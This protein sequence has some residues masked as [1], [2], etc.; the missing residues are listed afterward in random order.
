[1]QEFRAANP[2]LDLN[3][4]RMVIYAATLIAVM[5]LRPEGV[6]G[7]REIWEKKRS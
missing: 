7:E 1:M 4:L 2:W 3:A 5:I 6:L